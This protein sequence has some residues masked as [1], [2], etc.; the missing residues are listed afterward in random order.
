M[1]KGFLKDANVPA[2]VL[3]RLDGTAPVTTGRKSAADIQA[4]AE[5]RRGE[6]TVALI[7]DE[8]KAS[9]GTVT[10]ALNAAVETGT[11]ELLEGSP[12]RYRSAA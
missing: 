6:F 4:H 7:V 5:Q 8:T 3:D 9:K 1:L 10:K 11:I 12:K 2:D